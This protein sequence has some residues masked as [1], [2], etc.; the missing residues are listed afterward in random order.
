M[1]IINLRPVAHKGG[2]KFRDV[3]IFD[4]E[5][6]DGLRINGLKLALAPDGKRFVF[7]PGHSG[8]RFCTFKGDYARLLADA[9][10]ENGGRVANDKR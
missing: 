1:Q 6:V 7:S 4:A 9:V 3:A 2:D 5:I 8:E 10:W